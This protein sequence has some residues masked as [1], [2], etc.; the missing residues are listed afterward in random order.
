MARI[1]KYESLSGGFR[2]PLAADYVGSATPVGV[3]LNSSGRVV[4]GGVGN[5]VGS[6]GVLC[7]PDS[8]KAG[9]IVDIM[10]DGELVEFAGAAG[11][12][13]YADPT[14]GAINTT[15]PGAGVNGFRVGHT[16]EA[17]RLIVR[18]QRMQG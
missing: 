2:A 16:V 5:T 17:T 6:V 15:V 18:F 10:T 9:S 13:Y 11:T 14:T 8:A 7:K 4:L 3:S 12:V 1:D